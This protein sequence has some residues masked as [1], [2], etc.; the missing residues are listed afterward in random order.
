MEKVN[1]HA[2][3][4]H[5][6]LRQQQEQA[7]RNFSTLRATRKATI[8]ERLLALVHDPQDIDTKEFQR[9]RVVNQAV[10]LSDG[11]WPKVLRE[12]QEILGNIKAERI[13]KQCRER[14]LPELKALYQNY[15]TYLPDDFDKYT[16]PPVLDFL[17][18][19]SCQRLLE[20][21]IPERELRSVFQSSLADI[22]GD[23]KRF[24]T[25]LRSDLFQLWDSHQRAVGPVI[26]IG[27]SDAN[28]NDFTKYRLL[29]RATTVFTCRLCSCGEQYHY[30]TLFSGSFHLETEL[31]NNAFP[32]LPLKWQDL[33]RRLEANSE[34]CEVMEAIV[35]RAKLTPETATVEDLDKLGCAFDQPNE[36]RATRKI[37]WRELY[38]ELIALR[39]WD[40]FYSHRSN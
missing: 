14:N 3:M 24:Q 31:I 30:D 37:N 35:K 19:P 33:R 13:K 8:R 29:R 40:S 26:D 32:D 39:T 20:G 17:E 36:D 28:K 11:A 23:I 21:S 1:D 12:L 18:L 15:W 9:L 38:Q 6:W 16:M 25:R 4:L 2:R 7:G 5:L 34:P 22:N 27:D 10:E